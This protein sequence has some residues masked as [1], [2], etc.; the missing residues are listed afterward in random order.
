MEQFFAASFKPEDYAMNLY[1]QISQM[2][3][4]LIQ[5][6]KATFEGR[7]L[8]GNRRREKS[9]TEEKKAAVKVLWE[10]HCADSRKET[11]ESFADQIEEEVGVPSGTIKKWVT[12]F[13]KEKKR[14]C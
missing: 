8:G 13:R 6:N 3:S 5:K 12:Q 2:Y 9:E 7:K 1:L 11:I 10:Q 4:D 14:A